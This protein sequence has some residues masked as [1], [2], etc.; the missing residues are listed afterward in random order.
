[1][2]RLVYRFLRNC[3]LEPPV[4]VAR[5]TSSLLINKLGNR[6]TLYGCHSFG[7]QTLQS[8]LSNHRLSFVDF[9]FFRLSAFSMERTVEGRGGLGL[10]A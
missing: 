2:G 9:W 8:H 6:G 7:T 5:L 4:D 10:D 3:C 1:M